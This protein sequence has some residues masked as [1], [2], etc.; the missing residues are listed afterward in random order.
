MDQAVI[1]MQAYSTLTR[2]PQLEPLNQMQFSVILRIHLFKYM[3]DN[4]ARRARGVM[5]I[6]VEN[7]HGDTSSN[8]GRGYLHFIQL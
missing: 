6:I 1:A 3:K 4:I 5:V 2:T 8:R 7:G